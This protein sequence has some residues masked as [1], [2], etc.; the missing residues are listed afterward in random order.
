MSTIELFYELKNAYDVSTH[1]VNRFLQTIKS[2]KWEDTFFAD[3]E[4]YFI[5]DN[6][7]FITT[8]LNPFEVERVP[9]AI[10]TDGS[11]VSF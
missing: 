9:E 11:V 1:N 7:T 6:M 5:K 8:S 4:Y 2:I 10:F 3:D